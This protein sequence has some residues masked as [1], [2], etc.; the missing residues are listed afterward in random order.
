MKGPIL[1]SHSPLPLTLALST[2]LQPG[3]TTRYDWWCGECDLSKGKVWESGACQSGPKI[4]T[5]QDGYLVM[6][7]I[8]PRKAEYRPKELRS[9]PNVG[10]RSWLVSGAAMG[11]YCIRPQA[12]PMCRSLKNRQEVSNLLCRLF[13]SVQLPVNHRLN[14]GR[15]LLCQVGSLDFHH[16]LID[17]GKSFELLE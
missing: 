11:N 1:P 10:A 15:C 3:S 9:E 17:H 7:A 2:H 4:G 6:T 14:A 5:W 12:R 13:C 16:A 8:P